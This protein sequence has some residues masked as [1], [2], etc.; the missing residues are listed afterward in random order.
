MRGQRFGIKNRLFYSY[1]ALVLLAVFLFCAILFALIWNTG[2]QIE[3][4][5]QE[6]IVRNA[7]RRVES[8][9]GEMDALAS[10]AAANAPLINAFIP[11]AEDGD[12]ANFFERHV[13]ES[14]DA[15]S[16]L[17]T[18]NGSPGKAARI[19]AYNWNGDYVSTGVRYETRARI[20]A[21]LSDAAQI[22]AQL[23]AVR[24]REARPLVTPPDA[25]PW[26]D[27]D[28]SRMF[29]LIRPLANAY[30]SAVYGLVAVQQD[31][32]AL[33]ELGVFGVDGAVTTLLL[34]ENGAALLPQNASV[35]GALLKALSSEPANGIVSTVE[36]GDSMTAVFGA[37]EMSGW[38]VVRTQPMRELLRPYRGTLWSAAG[39]G[40]AL[41]MVLVGV[42]YLMARRITRPLERF[43][44]SMREVSLSNM[45][46]NPAEAEL[47]HAPPEIASLNAS[48]EGMLR[49]LS[50]SIDLEMKAYRY[51]LQSQMNPHFLFNTLAVVSASARESEDMRVV[52]M[53]DKLSAMLRY[54]FSFEGDTATMRD[55]LAHTANYL[56]LMKM[57]YEDGFSYTIKSCDAPEDIRVPKLILQPIAENCFQHGF[58][59]V[60]PPWH[61][62]I[63][64]E[65]TDGNW[66]V[67]VADNGRGVTQAEID[68]QNARIKR[69]RSDVASNYPTLRLGGMGLVNT[70][71]RLELLRAEP[72][73]YR[74]E[75]RDVGGTII[76]LGGKL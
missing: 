64:L 17:A 40:A 59:D 2:A 44:R 33:T 54:L 51:A 11:L 34:D 43:S 75:R 32:R 47:A 72:V 68:E 42:V 10:Q 76:T 16:L 29:S 3:R 20:D 27:N 46:L 67:S 7:I 19:S 45:A 23:D 21:T 31:E 4:A 15:S 74:I 25:D 57:R 53:C 30:M 71:L 22:L 28:E 38:R 61:I 12:T 13:L 70:I 14:I 5:N 8:V 65:R 9:L 60:R 37:V 39:G 63:R 69:F 49:R 26:S 55:E 50:E 18:I 41:L 73:A 6:E 66:Q 56:E 36:F 1:S 35:D 52:Q 48:F 58:K 24:A 62:D